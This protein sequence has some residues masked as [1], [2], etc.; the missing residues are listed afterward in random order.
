MLYSTTLSCRYGIVLLIH[1]IWLYCNHSHRL[2]RRETP[3]ND[4]L[5]W[6]CSIW[7]STSARTNTLS[8]KQGGFTNERQGSCLFKILSL[9]YNIYLIASFCKM[10]NTTKNLS[11]YHT[12]NTIQGPPFGLY[13]E[14]EYAVSPATYPQVLP[15]KTVQIPSAHWVC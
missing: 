12:Y 5:G 9:F 4:C 3:G 13:K 6:W 7:P 14:A 2:L 15:A 11:Q 1:R 8:A 10:K